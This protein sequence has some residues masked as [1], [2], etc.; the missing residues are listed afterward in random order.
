MKHALTAVALAATFA[1]PVSAQ[2]LAIVN[3]KPVPTARLNAL[4][5]QLERS[6]RPVSEEM[7]AQLKEEVIAR[8]I[9]MQE[10]ERRGLKASP[11]YRAQME[12]ASQSILIRELFADFQRKNKISDA[13]VQAEYDK[14]TA[15][16]G[17]QEYRTRHILVETEAEAKDI[18]ANLAKGAKF[19]ELAK[20]LSKDPGSGANGGDLDWATAATFVPEFSQAMV[21]LNKGQTTEAPVK[22][23]FGWHVIR[24]DDLRQAA[25]PPLAEL[26][27][28]IEQQ[29]QQQKLVEFQETLRSKA[30][31]Q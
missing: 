15:A 23:Q 24:L 25:L 11:D 28:Q 22:S 8:E 1:L 18:I 17:G 4:A 19:E 10:A 30:K 7:K 12:L 16:N 14:F 26:K 27:P 29:L 31:V 21:K 20:K 2:N 5:Q 3:G 13:D 9:F 6:G